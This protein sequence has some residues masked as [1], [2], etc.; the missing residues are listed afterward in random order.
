MQG[1]SKKHGQPITNARERKTKVKLQAAKMRF[2]LL[3]LQN[4]SNLVIV[5][6]IVGVTGEIIVLST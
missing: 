2:R 3:E 5:L 4:L 1:P 6:L